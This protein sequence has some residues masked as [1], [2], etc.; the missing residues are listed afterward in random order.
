MNTHGD[1]FRWFF[2]VLLW[3][4][5]GVLLVADLVIA[6]ENTGSL[7]R[8]LNNPDTVQTKLEVKPV[9]IYY[10]G[11]GSIEDAEN[12]RRYLEKITKER[13][14]IINRP[15]DMRDISGLDTDPL[16]LQDV[17]NAKVYEDIASNGQQNLIVVVGYGTGDSYRALK[18]L[19]LEHRDLMNHHIDIIA[20]TLPNLNQGN[21]KLEKTV[22]EWCSKNGCYQAQ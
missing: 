3:F 5:A 22:R 1:F 4:F 13:V 19:A 21:E 11:V 2:V 16:T 7:R 20:T 12:G 15:K 10:H 6:K 18:I 8:D 14:G 17:V 9:R